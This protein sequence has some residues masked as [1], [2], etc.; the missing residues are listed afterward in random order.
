M[1]ETMK[2]FLR[3]TQPLDMPSISH[4]ELVPLTRLQELTA[5]IQKGHDEIEHT[6]S[7]AAF[8]AV[9]RGIEVGKCL[10]AGHG[11]YED[12]LARN[13]TFTV[14]TAQNYTRLAKQEAKL[15]QL[16]VQ[17]RTAGSFLPMKEALELVA[18][19][20]GKKPPRR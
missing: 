5:N 10:I 8:T 4:G 19:L 20:E 15:R 7:I 9:E 6:L 1:S 11:N 16:L 13:F 14:K 3:S 12:Y 2:R 17:K 18:M